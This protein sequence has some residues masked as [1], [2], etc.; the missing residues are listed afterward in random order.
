MNRPWAFWRRVQYGTGF[1]VLSALIV[2]PVYFIYFVKEPTCF[3]G[4][5]NG[6]ERGIDCGGA[7]QLVCVSDTLP[8]IALWAQSFKIVDGQYNAVAYAEN[9]NTDVG[10]PELAY[11]FR[12]YDDQGL[13]TERSGTTVFPPN[14]TYPIFEGRIE[15]GD[16][17]PNRTTIEFADTAWRAGEVGRDQFTL[18]GRELVGADAL[19]RLITRLTNN[20]LDTAKDVEVVAVIFNSQKQPLTASRTFI[21]EFAGRSTQEVVLTWPEPIAKTLRSCEVP[22]DVLLA[23]D[24]S[25]SMNDD[26]G[27]PP[28]PVTSV[29]SAAQSFVS[30][31]KPQDQIGI[32]TYATEA[33]LRQALTNGTA[34]VASFVANLTI[35]PASEHG[36][37]NT[38][39]A[40][41]QITQELSS[42]RHNEN[43]RKVGI[44]LTDGLAT[45]PG[46]DP[47]AYARAK[48][49]ELKAENIELF[50]IGLGAK[51]DADFLRALASD[52]AH[53]FIAPSAAEVEGIYQKITAA[54]CEDGP[55]VIEVIPKPKTSFK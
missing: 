20:S 5:W 12:L 25:G 1:A 44:I 21:D 10:S 8:P 29:L 51:V 24:L 49:D 37:T 23:I 39:D 52:S 14:G 13:I 26:G 38:G 45:S 36:S 43:A 46:D 34:A 50:A 28:E 17:I 4:V 22:T 42:S 11:T 6:M 41:A 53:T 27:T 33:E 40:L 3:D 19:P 18:A 31:L 9:R 55:S 48:A 16:R 35:D 7:C 30:R 54:I 2:V 47:S 15:T 32:V